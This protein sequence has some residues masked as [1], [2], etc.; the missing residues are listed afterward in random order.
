MLAV[1]PIVIETILQLA[2]EQNKPIKPV[3]DDDS[4]V[5]TLGFTSLEVAT[6]VSLLETKLE[7]DPFT[8]GIAA[9]TDIRTVENLC[10]AYEKALK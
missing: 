4:L 2:K 10:T 9:I 1:K 3:Q 7:V 8:S 6:L 5:D